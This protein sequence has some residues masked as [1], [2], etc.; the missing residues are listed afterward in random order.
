MIEERGVIQSV[1][2]QEI[3]P[4]SSPPVEKK[5]VVPPP[6]PD[7]RRGCILGGCLKYAILLLAVIV[8]A[9]AVALLALTAQDQGLIPWLQGGYRNQAVV[10]L[11][12]IQNLSMLT[13]T[14]YN[15]SSLV[16]SEREMPTFLRPLYGE[17]QVLIAV[18]H[19]TAGIDLSR[20]TQDDIVQQGG[21]ITLRLPPPILMDC[22]LDE[23]ASYV[24]ERSTGL[25]TSS[26]PNLEGQARQFAV[27]KFRD[28]AIANGVLNDVQQQ[29]TIALTEF[30]EL[31]NLPDVTAVNVVPAAPDPA[32]PLPPSCL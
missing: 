4:F 27:Q 1:D 10:V 13:T 30:I 9:S 12:S 3:L 11:D 15:F 20:M 7:S 19:I 17:Q 22:F 31:L 23:N 8:A 24:A 26:A 32:A 21:A 2:D 14:R 6:P 16:T 29:A 28:E 5:V 25:F 18:G